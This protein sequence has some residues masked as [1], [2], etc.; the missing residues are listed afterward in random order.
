MLFPASRESAAGTGCQFSCT[1]VTR[2]SAAWPSCPRALGIG[3]GR[4]S[5]GRIGFGR[6][7]ECREPLELSS[8]IGPLVPPVCQAKALPRQTANQ[9]SRKSSL[10]ACNSFPGVAGQRAVTILSCGQVPC[11]TWVFAFRSDAVGGAIGTA[12]HYIL[13]G[14]P[15]TDDR[16][17]RMSGDGALASYQTLFP[18]D[19]L[20]RRPP[21]TTATPP[22]SSDQPIPALAGGSWRLPV[23]FF[24][25]H[26]SVHVRNSPDST[27]LALRKSLRLPL[28]E[29]FSVVRTRLVRPSESPHREGWIFLNKS[30][31]WLV[32][33]RAGSIF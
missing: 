25:T 31:S 32:N 13:R 4:A 19:G 3:R 11:E 5:F 28:R 6:S 18:P 10:S 8:S 14:S 7:C 1:D 16:R 17:R 2:E 15:T 23:S 9:T 33:L 30:C 29:L 22:D 12:L 24:A 26:P 27:W 20:W 21:S